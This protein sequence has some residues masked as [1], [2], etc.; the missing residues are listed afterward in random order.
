MALTLLTKPPHSYIYTLINSFRQQRGPQVVLNSLMKGLGEL[1]IEYILNPNKMSDTAIVLQNTNALRLAINLKKQGKIKALFAG[2]NIVI[3]PKDADNIL[4]N[5]LIDKI[6]VPSQWVKD[7]YSSLSPIIEDKIYIWS[8]GVDDPGEPKPINER[9]TILIYQKN[10]SIELLNRL[11]KS[12]KLKS[13]QV[14]IITYGKY[15]QEDYFPKLKQTK[16]AIFL[17]QSES[18]G[19][20]QQEAWIRDVPTLIWNPGKWQYNEYSWQDKKISSPYLTDACG[21]FFTSI[22]EFDIKLIKMLNNLSAYT[23]RQYA[24]NNFTH[25]KSAQNFLKIIN[26]SEI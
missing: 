21:T 7:F 13:Y 3:T 14:E 17:T 1:K 10:G 19:I 20:A 8:A 22:E 5:P 18:Q 11:V 4:E 15:K 6:I 25:K 2:P 9:D 12:L 23:P 16:L 24:L 26:F